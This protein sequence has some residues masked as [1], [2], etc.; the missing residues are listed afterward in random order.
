[1]VKI[2]FNTIPVVLSF[3]PQKQVLSL[4][5][6]TNDILKESDWLIQQRKLWG[7]KYL[8]IITCMIHHSEKGY[9]G[10]S[11]RNNHFNELV[12]LFNNNIKGRRVLDTYTDHKKWCAMEQLYNEY[13][14]E[15]ESFKLYYLHMMTPKQQKEFWKMEK[16]LYRVHIH[17]KLDWSMNRIKWSNDSEYN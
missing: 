9:G 16:S 14:Y 17:F 15:A 12:R 13:G 7:L 10:L 1:M 2:I 5:K 3:M 8:S 6:K 4:F 11:W